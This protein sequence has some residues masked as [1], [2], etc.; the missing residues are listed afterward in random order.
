MHLHA[1]R[2]D[3]RKHEGGPGLTDDQVAFCDALAINESAVQAMGDDKLKLIAAEL[4]K[5]GD[6]DSTL[7]ENVRAKIKVIV[8]RI[9][10]RHG[11][12]PDLQ[13]EEVKTVL[14]QAEL[15]CAGATDLDRNRRRSLARRRVSLQRTGLVAILRQRTNRSDEWRGGQIR[16]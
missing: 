14:A 4:N 7:R 1:H 12:S 13:E 11:Y 8:K 3:G 10:N 16:L 5:S 9:L 6:I 15:L 2:E